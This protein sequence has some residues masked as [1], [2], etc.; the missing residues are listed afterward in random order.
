M[1]RWCANTARRML[2]CPWR[3]Q[4]YLELAGHVEHAL[5]EREASVSSELSGLIRAA[6]RV[7][8]DAP[9]ARALCDALSRAAIELEEAL[10]AAERLRAD[11]DVEAHDLDALETRFAELDRLAQS[12]GVSG[13]TLAEKLEGLRQE[14]TLLE[15]AEERAGIAEAEVE[16]ATVRAL[17][18]ARKLHQG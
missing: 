6:A 11:L 7:A 2:T 12:L 3:A 13:D 10:R 1:P 5:S 9:Q 8:D 17:D 15:G 14:Q 18:L 4:H 16:S